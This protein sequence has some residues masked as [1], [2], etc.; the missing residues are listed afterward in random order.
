MPKNK[1]KYLWLIVLLLVIIALFIMI[2]KEELLEEEKE[3]IGTE[4]LKIDK[5]KKTEGEVTKKSLED[6]VNQLKGNLEIP[7]E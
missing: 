5:D 4:I 6:L 2:S 3:E 7:T 1:K